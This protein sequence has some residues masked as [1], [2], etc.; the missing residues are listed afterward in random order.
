[1]TYPERKEIRRLIRLYLETCSCS[2]RQP[3]E[4]G[5]HLEEHQDHCQF[6]KRVEED[7]KEIKA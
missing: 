4:R 5:L 3:D 1:M 7:G 6:R 2:A